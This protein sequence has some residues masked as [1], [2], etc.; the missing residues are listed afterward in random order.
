MTSREKEI[1]DFLASAGWKGASRAP[2]VG[3][4]SPRQ[5][6]RL[7]D[8]AGQKAVLMMAGP[9]Q[10]TANFIRIDGL[11]RDC[12]LAAPEIYAADDSRGLVLMEDFGKKNCGHLLDE[13]ADR[14]LLDAGAMTALAA[15]HRGFHAKKVEGWEL[16]IFNSEAFS[17]QTVRFL[18][19]YFPRVAGRAASAEERESFFAVW[20]GVLAPM[21]A[22]P[23]TLVLRD[24][25]PDNAMLLVKPR[26]A[27]TLGLLDFQDAGLGPIAYDICSWFEEVR[28]PGGFARLRGGVEAYLKWNPVWDANEL[29]EVA[30][31]L[32]AHQHT[33]V[34]GVWVDLS[35]DHLIPQALG[36]LKELLKDEKLEP[37]SRW[38]A[39]HLPL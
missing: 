4:A 36:G 10:K 8:K 25:M 13:G 37:V 15:L 17:R 28:R 35:R 5:Y 23:R 6:M 18:D 29:Y 3:D 38:F 1:E 31:L 16:P 14:D 2:M 27:Q 9:D 22:L 12:G 11:L 7:M 39:D 32:L 34:L 19:H 33:R 30:R 21:D 26:G 20:R 24:F